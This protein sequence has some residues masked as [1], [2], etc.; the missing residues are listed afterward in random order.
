MYIKRTKEHKKSF[1]SFKTH[2]PHNIV[3]SESE[4]Q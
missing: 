2:Q 3:W 4:A 1:V